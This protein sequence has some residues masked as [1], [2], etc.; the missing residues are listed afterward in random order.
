[1]ATN[2]ALDDRII[3]QAQ[4]IGHHRTKKEA[5]MIALKEYIA[6]KKQLEILSMFGKIEF[7][8][9]YNYKNARNR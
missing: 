7:D 1:M 5:V 9:N 2:L 3:V 8:E 6:H 4:K